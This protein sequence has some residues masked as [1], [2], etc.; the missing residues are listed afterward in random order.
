MNFASLKTGRYKSVHGQIN[1][2]KRKYHVLLSVQSLLLP[3]GF[4]ISGKDAYEPSSARGSISCTLKYSKHPDT[5]YTL[6]PSGGI[7]DY[8]GGNVISLSCTEVRSPSEDPP[9][10]IT[11]IVTVLASF[12]EKGFTKEI[13]S[14]IQNISKT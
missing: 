9:E 10:S 12:V 13:A 8:Y 1:I 5:P 4:N 3:K 14:L 11:E 2:F 6:S 7:Y